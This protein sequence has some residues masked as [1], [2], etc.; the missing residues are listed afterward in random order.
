M[1]KTSKIEQMQR[2]EQNLDAI[3]L[4]NGLIVF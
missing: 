4:G 2:F 1:E 3:D